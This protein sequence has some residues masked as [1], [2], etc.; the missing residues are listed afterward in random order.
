MTKREIIEYFFCYL[1]TRGCQ[2]EKTE[3]GLLTMIKVSIKTLWTNETTK[4]FVLDNKEAQNL[5][6]HSDVT[7]KGK[8]QKCVGAW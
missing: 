4:D 5:Q 1:K 6:Q 8:Y 3:V 7:I 2:K